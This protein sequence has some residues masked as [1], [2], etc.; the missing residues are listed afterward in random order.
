MNG[1]SSAV[2]VGFIGACDRG[3]VHTVDEQVV[4]LS[5]SGEPSGSEPKATVHH[6]HT[7]LHL[8]FS[9]FLFDGAGRTLVQQRAF[10]KPTWPGVWSNACCGHPAP[11]EPLLAAAHRRLRHELGITDPV[12]LEL[13]LPHFR[14]R[15]RWGELWENEV[16][17]VFVGTYTGRL[18]PNPAEV[19]SVRWIRWADFARGCRSDAPSEFDA[20]SPWSRWEAAELLALPGFADP[21]GAGLHPRIAHG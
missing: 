10:H 18:A 3:C 21:A 15:A 5:E 19:A 11:G 9:V 14:Y 20:F 4:L 7:P 6:A 12:G 8:A 16:C 1:N 2:H 13:A 17:P